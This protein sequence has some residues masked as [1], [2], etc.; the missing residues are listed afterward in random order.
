MS[1][2]RLGSFAQ[3]GSRVSLAGT[4]LRPSQ[5]G[6]AQIGMKKTSAAAMAKNVSRL[7]SVVQ[8]ELLRT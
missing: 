2:N 4:V 5:P 1:T 6:H 7:K 8:E 3:F